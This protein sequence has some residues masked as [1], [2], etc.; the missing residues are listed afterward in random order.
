VHATYETIDG[1][2]ALRFE[3]RL[4]HPPEQ[5]WRALTEPA[6]LAD[7]FPS[8]VEVDLR[9]GGAM[10]FDFVEEGFT[11]SGEVTALEAPRRFAFTWGDDHLHFD[12]E[13]EDGGS[14]CMLHFLVELDVRD[15]AAR[16]ASGWHQCFDRLERLLGGTEDAPPAQTWHE[17]YEEYAR[18]GMPVG[19][20][21]PG[22]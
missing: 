15:K 20:S 22:E 7:W 1:R 9:V 2:P 18:R 21:I 12:L 16:D 5:V 6:Q 10:H 17:L 14:A 11:L 3:R 8:R 4:Q 13:P 19:A